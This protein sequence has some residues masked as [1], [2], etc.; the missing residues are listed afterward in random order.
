[1][2]K[3]MWTDAMI[4]RLV[5]LWPMMSAA[6]IAVELGISRNAVTGKAHRMQ[7]K[8]PKIAQPRIPGDRRKKQRPLL[9]IVPRRTE[10]LRPAAPAA[11]PEPC[12]LHLDL[13]DLSAGDCR[14]PYG[15][16]PFTFCG[17]PTEAGSYC[18]A[19]AAVA[20]RPWRP[21]QEREAEENAEQARK[22]MAA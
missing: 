16:G 1:M 14:W 9:R 3:A 21:K 4:A 22:E 18:A 15:E 5:E 19:H 6:Q 17:R 7:I 10:K 2:G 11:A 8:K 13:L 12:P 20:F